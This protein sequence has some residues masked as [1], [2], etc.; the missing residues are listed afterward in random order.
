[1]K[2]FLN[3]GLSEI[4]ELKIYNF[5]SRFIVGF[6][7]FDGVSPSNHRG[8]SSVA[9]T[10]GFFCRRSENRVRGRHPRTIGAFSDLN[11]IGGSPFK[12]VFQTDLAANRPPSCFQK[13]RFRAE[14]LQKVVDFSSQLDRKIGESPFPDG[15]RSEPAA[16]I[17]FNNRAPARSILT[18]LLIFFST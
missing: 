8:A 13:S 2:P 5:L 9:K 10:F 6:S 18:K 16:F 1:M 15:S 3:F 4:H 14:H 12:L 7:L 11:K 17:F